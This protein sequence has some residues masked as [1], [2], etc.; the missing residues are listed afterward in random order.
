M[1][2]EL[3]YNTDFGTLEQYKNLCGTTCIDIH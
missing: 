3:K 1:P 2:C